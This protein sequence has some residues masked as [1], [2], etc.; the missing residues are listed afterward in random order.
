LVL[1][2]RDHHVESSIYF[3]CLP[4]L[5]LQSHGCKTNPSHAASTS[6][7]RPQWQVLLSMV[8]A[9]RLLSHNPSTRLHPKSRT[10]HDHH[11]VHMRIIRSRTPRL[12]STGAIFTKM[13]NTKA[14]IN[15]TQATH[16]QLL[17]RRDSYARRVV[18]ILS[19]LFHLEAYV[20]TA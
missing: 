1:S 5:I 11:M 4:A 14:F 3:K 18:M 17:R 13:P 10:T 16:G 7:S 9:S 15:S 2:S 12:P 8:I 6:P 19:K 20:E